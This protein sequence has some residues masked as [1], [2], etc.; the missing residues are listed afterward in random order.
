MKQQV[1]TGQNSF[2]RIKDFLSQKGI[3]SIF[4][5]T[6]GHFQ[7]EDLNDS[8]KELLDPFKRAVFV[9]K[10]VDVSFEE[11]DEAYAFYSKETVDCILAIGGG[12]VM[13]LAKGLIYRDDQNGKSGKPLLIAVPTTS[14]SG[15]E[16]TCI[17]VVYENKK[18]Q[19]LENNKLLPDIA[20]LDPQFSFSLPPRQTAIS[21]I[22]AFS[23]AI[24]SFWSIH[25]TAHSISLAKQ[26]IT[27]LIEYLP[28]AVHAPKLEIREKVLWASHLS[29]QAI[30]MTRTTG[31]HALSYFLSAHYKIP[32]GQAVGLFLPV[33]FLYNSSVN[34][35]NCNHPDGSAAVVQ[36]MQKL[37]EILQVQD[38][39]EAMEYIRSFMM[40]LGL[41]V[42]FKS[43]GIQKSMI[44]DQLIKEVNQQRFKNNP[45]LFNREVLVDLF[46][47]YL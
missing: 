42:D 33:F 5:I 9:K 19:S 23:Q 13:D 14:G 17:A 27:T 15:S 31:P 2:R 28:Q 45:V 35:T 22:D 12:S 46:Q 3:H 39:K 34:E 38:S 41:A 29:G 44:L 18:K 24:E 4:I 1:L 36:S 30:N 32:H 11:I 40:S 20:V 47:Q 6:G 7:N 16:A 25:A 43:L 8:V 10:G 37:N 26:A 21:G